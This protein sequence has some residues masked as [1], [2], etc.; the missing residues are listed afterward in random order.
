MLIPVNL[1]SKPGIKRDGTRFE[2][3]Y[4]VD[5]QWVRFQRGLPRK[6]GGY[7]QINNYINGVVR[8]F[9]TQAL[10]N[11]VYTHMGYSDGIQ[12]LTIDSIGNTS[13]PIDRTPV[14]YAG[15]TNMAWQFDALYDGAGSGTVLIAAPSSSTVDISSGT[16]LPV[17]YG[18]IYGSS[19]LSAIPG[20][21]STGGIVVLHPYLFVFGDDG[22]VRWSDANDP[23]NFATGDAGDAW[24]SSSK[25][26]KGLPLRG[27]GQSPAGIFWTLDSVMRCTYTGGT[28]CRDTETLGIGRLEYQR[29]RANLR[30]IERAGACVEQVKHTVSARIAQNAHLEVRAA[31]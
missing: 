9:Y 10:N 8:Q 25:I 28:A 30:D 15:D 29:G 19:A 26:V 4:Y 5:G 3:D 12:R 16:L 11:F 23:T 17:Y 1:K 2:G 24:I 14:L 20:V 6:I 22:Y 13:A 7:R 27:G 31:G 18:D 21:T